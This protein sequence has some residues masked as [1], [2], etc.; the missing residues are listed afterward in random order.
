LHQLPQPMDFHSFSQSIR[1]LHRLGEES[2][3]SRYQALLSGMV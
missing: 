2:K 1:E 3:R